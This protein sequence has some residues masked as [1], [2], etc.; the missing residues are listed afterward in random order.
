MEVLVA[1]VGEYVG[2]NFRQLFRGILT[3]DADEL[4]CL[5][6]VVMVLS[7]H[8]LDRGP[9]VRR[10]PKQARTISRV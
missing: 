4:L 5:H 7:V 9:T 2:Y 3:T 1:A 6:L 10:G 8:L